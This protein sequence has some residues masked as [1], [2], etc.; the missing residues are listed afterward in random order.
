MQLNKNYY[1]IFLTFFK[2]LKIFLKLYYGYKVCCY[3]YVN[4]S[5]FLHIM[6]D[7]LVYYAYGL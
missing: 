4:I 6:Q 5:I 7:F 1:I 2:L 3:C